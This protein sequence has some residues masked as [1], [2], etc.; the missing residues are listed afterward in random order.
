MK[1]YKLIPILA[2]FILAG[3]AK[4]NSI[5]GPQ[6]SQTQS[7]SQ[8]I[9]INQSSSLSVENTYS[10]SKSIDG[11]DGGSINLA[12]IFKDDGKWGSLSA[13]LTIPK[14]AFKGILVISYT[15]NTETASI[16]FSPNNISFKK[17]L[18]L[19]LIFT[20]LDISNYNTSL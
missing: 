9:I 12:K 11:K 2:I 8:W 17:N 4:E 6:S 20:G 7:K 14:N 18:S 15:V 19:D 16:D 13:N 10:V 5:M 3:C 1:Y